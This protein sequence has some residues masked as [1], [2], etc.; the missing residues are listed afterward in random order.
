[1]TAGGVSETSAAP[2]RGVIRRGLAGRTALWVTFAVVHAA[3][4]A[5]NLFAP[6]WPLGDVES[7]YLMWTQ[8]AA[9]GWLRVGI[10]APWVYPIL[11]FAPMTASLA[12]GVSWYPVTWLALMTLLDAIAFAVLLGRRRWSRP[13]RVAAWWWLGFLAALGPIAL[14]RIDA[15]T[16]PIALVG[17]LLAA[18]RPRVAAALL[19]VATWVKVWPAALLAALVI[20]HRRRFEIVTVAVALSVGII[21]VCLLAGSGLNVFGFI[22]QQAGRG[23]QVEAP[24]GVPWLWQIVAGT[25]GVEIEYDRDILTY[26]ITGPGVATAAAL[27]TPLMALGVLAVALVGIRAVR[28]GAPIGRILAP[29]ALALV[30]V[31][32]LAN[33]VG[34]PQFATWLA[35]PIVLGLATAPRRFTLPAVLAG[36]VALFTHLIYPYWYG[37][38][39]AASP[40]SVLLLTGKSALLVLLL[41]W[42]I[43]SLWQAGTERAATG[44]GIR[45]AASVRT[46]EE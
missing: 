23:L 3:L 8:Q 32:M 35:A 45:P 37:W 15:V 40:G 28:R 25:R 18:G 26:Q 36:L 5:L 6:G 31:L 2:H 42:G 43:R 21:G 27:T 19:T 22:G 7:V 9:N 30:I 34:S 39:L 4:A 29:L 24:I 11:A 33:K 20:A 12:F 13:R 17:L 41:G 14:G 10:D 46:G 1:M 38:L 44:G 16:V